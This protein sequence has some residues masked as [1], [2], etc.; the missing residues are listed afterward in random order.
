MLHCKSCKGSKKDFNKIIFNLP[1]ICVLGFI[2]PLLFSCSDNNGMI[3]KTISLSSFSSLHND[4]YVISSKYV[5]KSL[6][7]IVNNDTS[8]T[9][10]D[11]FVKKYYSK[12]KPF[13][14]VSYDGVSSKADSLVEFLEIIDSIGF[15]RSAFR[16]KQINA[17]IERLRSLNFDSTEKS[18]SRTIARLEYNLT[19]ALLIY[20]K[21]QR[22]G[23]TNPNYTL[24]HFDVK[25]SDSVRVN[26]KK[27]FDV[28]SLH[29]TDSFYNSIL[30]S[31]NSDNF[32]STLHSFSPQSSL[33]RRLLKELQTANSPAYRKQIIL[34]MEKCRWMSMDKA[35]KYGKLI[36]V[37]IPSYMLY[38]YDID[39]D[40][41]LTM[42]IGC[43]SIKTKTPILESNIYRMDI[44]P[45]WIIP[46]SIVERDIARHAGNL[47]YFQTHRYYICKRPSFERVNI[48]SVSYSMLKSGNYAVVQE[49]GEGNSLGRIIFRFANNFSVYLHDTSSR[50]VFGHSDRRV[51]HGCIR[52]QYPY[53]LAKFLLGNDN[54]SLLRRIEYSMTTDIRPKLIDSVLVE[55]D[56]DK[57]MLI[58]SVDLVQKVPIK[59]TYF[60]LYPDK[61]GNLTAYGDVYG[62]DKAILRE[63]SWYF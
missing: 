25:D 36:I 40:S 24:N 32:I 44:N 5:F 6:K 13:L 50:L 28:K 7:S 29:P 9:I 48:A 42:K 51:S 14:W 54:S 62:Y 34:N 61:T 16:I 39:N 37:N 30:E 10:S 2:I 55:P 18:I 58:K 3:N 23:F 26:F 47:N 15:S 38:A 63:L 12:G 41:I 59:I 11:R 1:F 52:V 46:Q 21:G 22:Y 27:L 31:V 43:G 53:L 19:R 45:I 4:D 49:G 33:Y 8:N 57:R 20:C 35:S 56:I 17:D 60:T